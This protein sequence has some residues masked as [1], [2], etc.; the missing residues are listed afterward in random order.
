VFEV[1]LLRVSD[2]PPQDS[3]TEPASG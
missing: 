3:D 2:P 1:R